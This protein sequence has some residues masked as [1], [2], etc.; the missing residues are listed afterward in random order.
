MVVNSTLSH[1]MSALVTTLQPVQQSDRGRGWSPIS[2]FLTGAADNLIDAS[3]AV[4]VLLDPSVA[5]P[6]KGNWIHSVSQQQLSDSEKHFSNWIRLLQ[7]PTDETLYSS[8]VAHTSSATLRDAIWCWDAFL[9]IFKTY[10]SQLYTYPLNLGK[11]SLAPC[12][13]IRI[14]LVGVS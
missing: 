8:I 3:F 7:M 6:Q 11:Y 1:L 9:F 2:H 13:E 5:L 12:R 4:T 14:S 10:G